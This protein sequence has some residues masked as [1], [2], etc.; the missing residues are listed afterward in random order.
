MANW[1]LGISIEAPSKELFEE[2]V[3]KGACMELC[4]EP[5]DL[6]TMDWKKLKEWIDE[7]G[8]ELWSFHLPFGP[9]DIADPDEYTH[10]YA[11][12]L[13]AEY[14]K[15]SGELGAKIAVIHPSF[16]P[17][18]PEERAEWMTTAKASLVQLA[19]IAEAWGVTLAVEDLPRT[20]LGNCSADMLELLSADPR[21]RV[22][23]DTN[24]LLD[25]RNVG[26]VRALGD[27]I[28]TLHV[29]DYDF[30]N[31][32]HW[33]PGEGKVD[34]VELVTALEEAGYDGPFLYEVGFEAVRTIHR[35]D[36]TVADYQDNHRACLEKRPLPV[37]GTPN[38][39]VC[40][41]RAYYDVPKVH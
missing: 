19:E 5:H 13:Q 37:L 8:V 18:P 3:K 32:R 10:Q 41:E 28:I 34:W 23:F 21:L 26:F 9:L 39:E 25:E 27:R 40:D 35:R 36:M 15:R 6:V 16:E 30:R 4:I 12:A 20:C 7:S 11:V 38:R 14:I 24:H 1:K 29:S 31:E 22:C 33:M 2:M 17:I